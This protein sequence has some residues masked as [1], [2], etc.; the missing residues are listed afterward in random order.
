MA[1]TRWDPFR[2]VF[3]LHTTMQSLLQEYARQAGSRGDADALTQS[4]FI[5]PT[6]IF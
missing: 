3:G 6:D 1:V 5:P 2:D 4:A